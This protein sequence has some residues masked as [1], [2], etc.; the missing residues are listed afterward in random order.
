MKRSSS[1]IAAARENL[2]AREARLAE[3]LAKIDRD[4]RALDHERRLVAREREEQRATDSRLRQREDSLRQ[5]EESSRKRLNEAVEAEVRQAR[6]EID[7]IIGALKQKTER[8]AQGAGR[9]V[10][11]GETGQVR[12][13]ARAAVEAVAKKH[14]DDAGDTAPA[15]TPRRVG[16]VG[17]RSVMARFPPFR[18]RRRS[19]GRRHLNGFHA[20]RGRFRG[21]PMRRTRP[22]R[23]R[24]ACRGCR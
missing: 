24:P 23:P 9:L 22:T 7:E 1:C 13:D 3:H 19:R 17:V 21:T 6:K 2:S 20:P 11:T 10:T 12:S 18:Y 14:A 4:M 15:S 5:R 16:R 8:I